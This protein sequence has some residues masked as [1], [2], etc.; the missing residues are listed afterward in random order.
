M[1]LYEEW[2]RVLNERQLAAELA[3]GCDRR[4]LLLFG[5]ACL[6]RVWPLLSHEADRD[7]VEAAEAYADGLLSRPRL[8]EAWA[9]A[10]GG[11]AE[12]LWSAWPVW[13]TDCPCCLGSVTPER[14]ESQLASAVE[15]ATAWPW[16]WAARAA[17][18]A[19]ELAVWA[20]FPERRANASAAE[21]LAQYALLSD[22]CDVLPGRL[23]L[24]PAWLRREAAAAV[25]LAG[26]IYGRRTDAAPVLADALEEAGCGQQALLRHLRGPGPHVRGCWAI[27]AVLG[28]R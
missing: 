5:C 23:G 13:W 20:A 25:R 16:T 19:R 1:I 4:R 10:E 17:Y 7:A 12:G 27:D 21:M 15:E 26:A 6:R 28:K 3:F 18:Y 9:R 14:E 11:G 22:L 8:V 2:R 24:A